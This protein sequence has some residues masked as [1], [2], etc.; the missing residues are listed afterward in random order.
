MVTAQ[1]VRRLACGECRLE[2]SIIAL[3]GG[4]AFRRRVSLARR[5]D[6]RRC[7]CYVPFGGLFPHPLLDGSPVLLG[8]LRLSAVGTGFIRIAGMV[9][10]S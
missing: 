5:S 8:K 2:P 10:S 7:T 1:A 3:R 6:A 9:V 4:G